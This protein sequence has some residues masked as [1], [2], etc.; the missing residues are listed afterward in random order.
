MTE[1][2]QKLATDHA[3]WTAEFFKWVYIEAFKHGYKHGLQEAER[4]GWV[5]P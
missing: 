2:V 1:D 5:K 3:D 4:Q